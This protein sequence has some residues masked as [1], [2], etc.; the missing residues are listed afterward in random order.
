VVVVVV[1]DG[2]VVVVVVLDIG[3]LVVVVVVVPPEP[4]L[5]VA[6]AIVSTPALVQVIGTGVAPMASVRLRGL[7]VVN[8]GSATLS[9]P[10]DPA[11]MVPLWVALMTTAALVGYAAGTVKLP[12]TVS[13]GLPDPLPTVR[14]TDPEN[15]TL[16]PGVVRGSRF[17]GNWSTMPRPVS[18]PFKRF[19]PVG[20]VEAL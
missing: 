1:P 16:S 11:V 18:G 2:L 17:V 4:P 14:G 13:E 10:L 8:W 15:A 7:V 9:G 3:V 5:F 19:T 12:L 20:F 6:V